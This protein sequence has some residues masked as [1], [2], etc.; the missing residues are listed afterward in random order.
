[1]DI[2]LV[3]VAERLKVPILWQGSNMPEHKIVFAVLAVV[4]ISLWPTG[5]V[6]ADTWHLQKGKDFEQVSPEGQD[7]F[8][9]EVAE[10]KRL[11]NTGQT[12][13]ARSAFDKLKKDHSEIDGPDLD[14]FI[15]GELLF[16]EGKFTKA[17][18]AYD[19]L[20]VEHSQ[21]WLYEAALSREY[22]IATALLA[23]RKIRVLYFF[24]MKGYAT[25]A[26]IMERITDRAGDS[27][28]AVK[29]STAMAENY[30]KRKKFTEAY[31]QWRD[32]SS[33]WETG[34]PAKN[35]LFG[36]ARC[37]HAVYNSHPEHKR[38]MYD[39]ACLDSAKTYY[40]RFERLY[41]EEGK[42]LGTDETL[43]QINEQRALK[44]LNIAKYYERTGNKQAANLYYDM[45][46]RQWPDTQAAETARQTLTPATQTET[47]KDG[48]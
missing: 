20:L 46:T 40:E 37:K 17:V 43:M 26:K 24:K 27:S 5:P 2:I 12:K 31:L 1:M 42:K 7:S 21:S 15:K 23:G 44:E 33:R 13:A 3:I 45:V 35:A 4:T 28:I 8:L 34:E 38:P 47:Q 6:L 18:R 41:P 11:V 39:A 10:I 29:A 9:L 30:E 32:L 16:S 14:A 22:D 25:A 19:E 48:G 36:M